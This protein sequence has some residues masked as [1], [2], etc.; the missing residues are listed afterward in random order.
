MIENSTS[1]LV[2]GV[3]TI[4][5]DEETFTIK[6]DYIPKMH[7]TRIQ[8]PELGAY[9]MTDY[10]AQGQTFPRAVINIKSPGS[11]AGPYVML[12]RLK[13]LEGFIILDDFPADK[14]RRKLTNDLRSVVGI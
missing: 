2:E 10:K 1:T 4:F 7:L 12:S 6:Q 14:V 8:L 3:F 9:A 13:S 5:P 11:N